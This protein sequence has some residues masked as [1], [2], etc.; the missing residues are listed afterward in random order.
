M[1]LPFFTLSLTS[2]SLVSL[3]VAFAD[4][5][6]C[7][8]GSKF[9]LPCAIY[10]CL[11]VAAAAVLQPSALPCWAPLICFCAVPCKTAPPSPSVVVRRLDL[12]EE[13]WREGGGGWDFYQT[14]ARDAFAA[15]H[16]RG[17]AF[18]P[19]FSSSSGFCDDIA[20]KTGVNSLS[21]SCLCVAFSLYLEGRLWDWD[22]HV[23]LLSSPCL[24]LLFLSFWHFL[25]HTMQPNMYAALHAYLPDCTAFAFSPSSP[26]LLLLASFL[27]LHTAHFGR[28]GSTEA[29]APPYPTL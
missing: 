7:R 22:T 5:T 18:Y 8:H 24:L 10:C 3:L 20:W 16:S 29:S 26:I 15:R 17:R 28:D 2:L 6:T 13:R 9:S 11:Y 14:F 21:F 12:G 27:H 4:Q 1:A 25:L 19:R 23:L